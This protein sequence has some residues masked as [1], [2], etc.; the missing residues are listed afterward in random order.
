MKHLPTF[1]MGCMLG[2]SSSLL[3]ND[4]NQNQEAYINISE[5]DDTLYYSH[6]IKNCDITC[7]QPVKEQCWG[8]PTI[9]A[10]GSKI[11]LDKLK[12]GYL[13]WCAVSHDI[14]RLLPKNKPKLIKIEGVGVFEVRD[15]T[16][17]RFKNRVD[18][19]IDA[20]DNTRFKVE[21]HTIKIIK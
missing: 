14:W 7:Y 5:N 13:R 9:T 12:K 11:N 6:I 8:D 15:K 2:L 3:V 16:N 19:L 21:R 17:A 1:I 18:I 10:D 4:I 20:K